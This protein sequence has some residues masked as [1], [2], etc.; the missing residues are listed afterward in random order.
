MISELLSRSGLTSAPK[1]AAAGAKRALDAARPTGSTHNGTEVDQ[2]ERD[3]TRVARGSD[4]GKGVPEPGVVPRTGPIGGD[5]EGPHQKP[6]HVGIEQRPTG[7]EPDDQNG[8]RH[9]APHTRE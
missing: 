8:A 7:P 9:I 5:L 2:P 6:I 4:C 3:G 1:R